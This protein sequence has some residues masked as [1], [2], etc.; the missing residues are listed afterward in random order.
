MLRWEVWI[1]DDGVTW[2]FNCCFDACADAEQDAQWYR[3]HGYVHV[4]LR[5]RTTRYQRHEHMTTS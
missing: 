2:R 3:D 1:S 4:A 5:M